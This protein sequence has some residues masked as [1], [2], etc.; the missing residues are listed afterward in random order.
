MSYTKTYTVCT[1]SSVLRR[2]DKTRQDRKERSR[3]ACCNNNVDLHVDLVAK[4]S[5]SRSTVRKGGC[6]FQ[7]TMGRTVLFVKA[8]DS[9]SPID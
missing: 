9:S 2:K 4:D 6:L 3:H 8:Q 7:S 5:R 1:V